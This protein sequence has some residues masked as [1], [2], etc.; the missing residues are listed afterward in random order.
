MGYPSSEEIAVQ[1]I[2]GLKEEL[3]AELK[4][5]LKKMFAL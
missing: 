2:E 3:K 1:R 5:D 4:E